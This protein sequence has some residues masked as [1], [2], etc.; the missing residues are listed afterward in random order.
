VSTGRPVVAYYRLARP[1]ERRELA[2]DQ[3]QLASWLRRRRRALLEPFV[4]G[5]CRGRQRPE[6]AR[7]LARCESTRATLLV[8]RLAEVGADLAFLE[9]LLATRVPL[10]AADTPGLRRSTLALLRDVARHSQRTAG[11]RVRHGL[12]GARRRGVQLGSPRPAI[13]A[14]RA[15]ASLR[16]RANARAQQL[17]PWIAELQLGNPDCSLRE[18]GRALEAL[19]LET[20]RG[21]RWGPSA[22]RNLLARA[23]R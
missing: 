18:L 16:E 12:E 21:G 3:Q 2:R 17:A 10:A 23:H 8:P 22:V 9:A 5:L 4:E 7:A 13:G 19:G 1:R 11:E 20:P 14:R 6:L 15:A